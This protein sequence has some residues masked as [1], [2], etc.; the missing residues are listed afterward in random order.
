MPNTAP[1]NYVL[2]CQIDALLSFDLLKPCSVHKNTE[3]EFREIFRLC[4][5]VS[6]FVPGV[7]LGFFFGVSGWSFSLTEGWVNLLAFSSSAHPTLQIFLL[8]F[9]S[10]SCFWFLLRSVCV[11]A[12]R[13]SPV[14]PLLV[15]NDDSSYKFSGSVLNSSAPLF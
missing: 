10:C 2:A 8:L 3:H 6:F 5:V 4:S 15:C 14:L 11:Q 7:G 1:L 12:E 9:S 13:S